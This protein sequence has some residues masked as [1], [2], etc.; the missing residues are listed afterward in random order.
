MDKKIFRILSLDGGGIRGLYSAK[1]LAEIEKRYGSSCEIFNLICGT[2]TGGIIALGLGLGKSADEIV[3]YYIKYGNQIFPGKNKI[4]KIKYTLRQLVMSPKYSNR[5]LKDSLSD[6]FGDARMKDSKCKLC[7]PAVNLTDAQGIMLKIPHS[8]ELIRDGNLKMVDVA[9][10]T[11]AAPTYFPSAGL[12]GVSS[13]CIDGGLWA[14]NPSF[15][16][17]IEAIS[18]FVGENKEFSKFSILSIGTI[19]GGKS[20][21]PKKH[22]T[23]SALRW[24]TKIFP[25]TISVQS[26]AMNNLLKIASEKGLFP[27][28]EYIRFE[29][30]LVSPNQFKYIDLDNASNQSLTLLMDLA[31]AT[32]NKY[33]GQQRIKEFFE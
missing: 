8:P 1:V 33:L 18:Y 23:A 28:G 24:A 30:P 4:Q 31:G 9:M 17:A 22:R 3:E 19:S 29:D 21:Y 15:I 5:I 7:I 14:N 12:D 20:W 27:M 16:G 13:N 11:S 26:N 2:S 25:L 10:A 32:A 6:F